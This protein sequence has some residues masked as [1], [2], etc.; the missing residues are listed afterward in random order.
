MNFI[1]CIDDNYNIQCNVSVYSLLQ[2]TKNK[3]NV[4]VLHKTQTD[5]SFFNKKV[6]NHKNLNNITVYKFN[7]EIKEFP[8]LINSHVSEATYYRLFIDN[9]LPNNIEE[10]IYVDADVVCINSFDSEA[11]KIFE[12]LKNKSLIVS[13]K[14]EILKDDTSIKLFNNLEMKNET[15]FNAGV[16]FIDYQKWTNQNVQSKLINNFYKYHGNLQ[17]W[18][19]DILNSY[20]DGSYL[21][22]SQKLN[23]VTNLY[24]GCDNDIKE[25]KKEFFNNFLIHYAGKHKPWTLVGILSFM[26]EVYQEVYFKLYKVRYH[27][28][29]KNRLNNIKILKYAIK[30]KSLFKKN[31]LLVLLFR[32]FTQ[33][34]KPKKNS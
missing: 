24:Y 12:E 14:T 22:L 30:D 27:I 8:N 10:L 2:N 16:L 4:Y 28:Q 20:F 25:T 7:T 31:K 5:K 33:F 21:E 26:S 19:Q 32:V 11:E 6:L 18:D 13:A 29:I 15:Y 23:K 3:V 1:Y 34:L 9:Y 17:F